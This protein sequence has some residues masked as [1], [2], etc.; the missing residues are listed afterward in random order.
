MS[1]PGDRHAATKLALAS[2]AVGLAVLA[3]KLAAWAVTGSLALLSDALETVV[4]IGTAAMA[5]WAVRVAAQPPDTK[6]PYGHHKAEVLSA[7]AEGVMIVLAALFILS[8]VREGLAAPALPRAPA[9]GIALVA[10]A[11]VLNGVWA[12]VLVRRGR[13]LRSPALVADGRHLA[14]DVATSVGVAGGVAAAALTGQAW[15][16]PALAAAVAAYILWSG[17]QVIRASASG[18]MDESVPEDER[19]LL[20]RV[21]AERG[22]GAVEAHDIRTRHAGPAR[23]VE[24][25][26][27]V[28]GDMQVE[29]AHRICDRIEA[30]IRAEMPDAR[31]TIHVEPEHKA[32]DAGALPICA[33]AGRRGRRD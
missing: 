17:W 18:L 4:N 31:V 16:D 8:E 26:L 6:H 19:A 13:A 11:S 24:F 3:L 9:A 33:E 22:A 10:L 23:F 32:H 5:L 7:V 20:D 2:L 1:G 21:I 15:L 28:P 25:H 29:E 30:G 12:T 14:A 27:V